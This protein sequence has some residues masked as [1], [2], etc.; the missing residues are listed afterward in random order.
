MNNNKPFYLENRSAVHKLTFGLPGSGIPS[1]MEKEIT[2][3]ANNTKDD[4]IIVIDIDGGQFIETVKKLGGVIITAKEI[5]ACFDEIVFGSLQESD[6]Q[7]Y[8]EVFDIITA[9]LEDLGHGYITPHQ[10]SALYEALDEMRKNNESNTINIFIQRLRE[11]DNKTASILEVLKKLSIYENSYN[12][13]NKLNNNFV[14]FD[15]GDCRKELK[16]IAYLLTLK[17]AKDKIWE[18]G[19][20]GIY[21]CLFTQISRAS[22]TEGICNYLSYLYKRTRQHW[23]LT[24]FYTASFSAFLNE[25]TLSLL[26]NTNEFIFLKQNACDIDKVSLYFDIPDEYLQ[27]LR[28]ASA[29]HG[30]WT[31][32]IQYDYVDY[33]K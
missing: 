14:C 8:C 12:A 9:I 21:T 19:D 3:I 26:R 5:F 4:N 32:G 17:M 6:N 1:I 29:G 31:D 23:G 25:Q 24:S 16:N 33:N 18:N 7:S 13:M 2:T 11:L 20:K 27:F 10:Q 22:L 15:L 30:V 28:H